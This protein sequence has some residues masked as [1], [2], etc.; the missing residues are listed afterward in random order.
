VIHT[1][2]TA[3][4]AVNQLDQIIS[5]LRTQAE[6][7]SGGLLPVS[8]D[9]VHHMAFFALVIGGAAIL[10]DRVDLSPIIPLLIRLIAISFFTIWL[11]DETPVI[12]RSIDSTLIT[13]AANAAGIDPAVL[14]PGRLL[15]QGMLITRDIRAA[16]AGTALFNSWN[17][18]AAIY[19]AIISFGLELGFVIIAG[20][21]AFLEILAYVIVPLTAVLLPLLVFDIT[22]GFAF[23]AI[24][25][26]IAIAISLMTII[27]F[28]GMEA[29]FAHTWVQAMDAAC[30]PAMQTVVGAPLT[31]YAG[32][33]LMRVCTSG[34]DYETAA[35]FMWCAIL[36]GFLAFGCT[37]LIGHAVG[38]SLG[39]GIEHAAGVMLT[40]NAV[41]RMAT[42]V[43]S[44]G[45]AAQGG[46]TAAAASAQRAAAANQAVKQAIQNS[47]P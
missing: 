31:A 17:F 44:T 7:I 32:P 21:F 18:T 1:F 40:A 39:N 13:V 12:T 8:H 22:R 27:A 45:K 19:S 9:L 28:A 38:M 3:G 34:I 30:K 15:E 47:I 2:K 5:L 41:S 14:T 42:S 29:R 11:I 20:T 6:A 25:F 10:I 16:A 23:G 33:H 35:G 4:D 43:M 24:R 36:Y 37:G 46:A 26:Y